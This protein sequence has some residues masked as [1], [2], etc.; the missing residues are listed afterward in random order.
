M[1]IKVI[2]RIPSVY[3]AID[4]IMEEQ[5]DVVNAL[6]IDRT[7]MVCKE[8]GIRKVEILETYADA[9][10]FHDQRYRLPEDPDIWGHD[11]IHLLT[12]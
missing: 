1:L 10:S 7:L 5:V 9:E 8:D 3:I 4:E 11:F 12:M 2:H 6:T